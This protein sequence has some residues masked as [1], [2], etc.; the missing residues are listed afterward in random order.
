M[1]ARTGLDVAVAGLTAQEA[2]RRLTPDGPNELPTERP[3][4]L[5]Q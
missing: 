5:L 3:R 1:V 2:A 4:N